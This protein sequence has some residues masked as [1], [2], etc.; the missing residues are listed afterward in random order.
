MGASSTIILISYILVLFA[1]GFVSKKKIQNADDYTLGGRKMPWVLIAASIAANDIGSGASLGIMQSAAN[2]EGFSAIWYIWLMVPAYFVGMLIAPIIRKTGARTVSG[3]FG[4]RY[5]HWA[6]RISALFMIV[7]NIGVISINFTASASVLSLLLGLSFPQALIVSLIA[8]SL[9]SYFG[10]IIADVCNDT[11]QLVI[12]LFGTCLTAMFIFMKTGYSLDVINNRFD[13][14]G[15]YT[16]SKGF[17]VFIVYA[18]TFIIGLSSTTRIYS[19]KSPKNIK[20]SILW[21]IPLY[22]VYAIV[23]VYIGSYLS[24][25]YHNN[26]NTVNMVLECLHQQLPNYVFVFVSLGII[27]ASLSTVDTLLI[28]CSTLLVNDVFNLKTDN[29]KTQL[30]FLR[31]FVLGFGVLGGII[32]IL[33]IKDVISFLIFMLSIQTSALM[34]PFL[35]GHFC[36]KKIKERG[37]LYCMAISSII[38]LLTSY[39]NIEFSIFTP[40]MFSIIG[41]CACLFLMQSLPAKCK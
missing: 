16:I 12:L 14:I 41:G 1:V 33:G 23:P 29:R 15:N 34:I 36:K 22:I 13:I 4:D 38:F 30:R 2:G 6:Q 28:G 20:K 37:C 32:A 9:Y 18:S 24:G 35:Y 21:L 17:S 19:S 27:A 25:Q 8:T 5:G 26:F 11:I 10:G 7:P 3:F 40:F 31:L 39:Y